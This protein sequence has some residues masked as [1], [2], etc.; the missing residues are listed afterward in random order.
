MTTKLALTSGGGLLYPEDVFAIWTYA[1]T[2]AQQDIINGINLSNSGGMVWTKA[3]ANLRHILMDTVRGLS[4]QSSTTNGQTTT[5]TFTDTIIQWRTDGYRLGVDSQTVVNGTGGTRYTSW[6]FRRAPGF[7]DVVSYTGNGAARTIAHGLGVTPGFMM[8]KRVDATGGPF[9][10][11]HS[12]QGTGSYWNINN[13]TVVASVTAWNSTAPTSSVFSVGADN[14]TNSNG[15]PYVAY[16]FAHN[17]NVDGMIQCGVY[18]GNGSSTGPTVTLGWEPQCMLVKA[19]TGVWN[20]FDVIRGMAYSYTSYQSA[21]STSNDVSTNVGYIGVL[22]TGFQI[23][24]SVGAL[25]TNGTSYQYIAIRRPNKTPTSAA[26]VFSPHTYTGN[27][28]TQTIT[29]PGF[30]VDT[31]I[32]RATSISHIG[33]FDRMRGWLKGFYT[34]VATSETTSAAGTDLTSFYSMTGY[35]LGTDSNYALNGGNQ[36]AYAFRRAR[37][38]FD[39]VRYV[40]TGSARTIS[41]ALGVVP[42]MILVT[43]MSG[44]TTTWPVYHVGL[45]AG[46]YQLLGSA[47][48][49]AASTTH[50]NNTTPTSSVFSVGTDNDTNLL[51]TRFIAYLF[52]TFPGISKVG[53]YTG[54]GTSQTIDCGFATG[55][56][57]VMIK[58]ATTTGAFTTNYSN[59]WCVADTARGLVTANDPVFAMNSTSAD[60]SY[61]WIDPANSGFIIN[62]DANTDLNVNGVAYIYLAI[63]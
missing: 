5:S 59:G 3:D 39:Q 22:P 9:M 52:A 1:G 38:F 28:S 8:V 16:L 2:G 36:I 54:N 51:N 14:D 55:A 40:G 48:A 50:W 58:R 61:D 29:T 7:F 57:F 18:T 35:S 44:A 41:H 60:G 26:Q 10:S 13:S 15:I 12:A 45:G 4:Q 24:T 6:T 17:T 43:G 32:G 34:T 21:P 62:Q 47:T 23:L 25:N 30:P 27:G 46:W 49:G 63:A 31:L 20:M 19:D 53:S 33:V 11:Y 42:E 56:R 37:G